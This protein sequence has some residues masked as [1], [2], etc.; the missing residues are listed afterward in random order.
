[1]KVLVP[2]YGRP[3]LATTMEAIECATIVVPE[4]QKQEYEKAYPKRVTAIPNN[5]DGNISKKRNA[6]LNLAKEGEL[7]W[8]IDDDLISAKIIK[9][10][11]ITNID[12]LLEAHYQLMESCK[13]DFGGFAITNDPGKYREYMPFSLYKPSYGAVCIRNIKKIRYDVE[14]T[15]YEDSDYFMQVLKNKG[16]IL[17]DNRIFLKFQCNADVSKIKQQGG[18]AGN[19]QAHKVALDKLV[20]KWGSYIKIKNGKMSGVKTPRG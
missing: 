19:E 11:E 8:I 5:Q 3:G 13:A 12:E 15:R 6:C 14:L 2:S 7:L 4:K 20:Y 17:R 10:T 9:G 18:I 1:M 16:K